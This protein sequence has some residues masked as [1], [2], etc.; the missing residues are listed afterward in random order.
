VVR[1]KSFVG[2]VIFW[3][4]KRDSSIFFLT[5]HFFYSAYIF[6]TEDDTMDSCNA[7]RRSL[8]YLF[9]KLAKHSDANSGSTSLAAVAASASK[10][11]VATFETS[12]S[13][14]SST[15][16]TVSLVE[17]ESQDVL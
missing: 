12:I 1:N 6:Y 10:K 13:T 4:N 11:L 3:R 9:Y 2:L 17:P 16:A 7:V 14:R 5:I 8:R 15:K